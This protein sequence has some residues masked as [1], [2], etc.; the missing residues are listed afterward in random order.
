MKIVK[1]FT[2]KQIKAIDAVVKSINAAKKAGV[3]FFGKC[4]SLVAIRKEY[5]KYAGTSKSFGVGDMNC[6]DS[7]PIPCIVNAVIEDSGAD[8]TIIFKQSF[9]D[10]NGIEPNDLP[11]TI[12]PYIGVDRL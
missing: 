5:S 9:Y 4:E 12:N 1:P 10:D 2:E 7:R 3:V 6:E 11:R 8:D